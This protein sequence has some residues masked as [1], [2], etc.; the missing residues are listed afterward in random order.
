MYRGK[1]VEKMVENCMCELFQREND[2]IRALA[3]YIYTCDRGSKERVSVG[4]R[5][6]NEG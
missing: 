2:G 6:P 5:C 4:V 1:E 3:P